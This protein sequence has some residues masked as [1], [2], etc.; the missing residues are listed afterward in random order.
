MCNHLTKVYLSH[1]EI[2]L[3][4]ILVPRWISIVSIKSGQKTPIQ[5]NLFR[6]KSG[7]LPCHDFFFHLL[8]LYTKPVN[9]PHSLKTFLDSGFWTSF[10]IRS[11]VASP[12]PVQSREQRS[13]QFPQKYFTMFVWMLRGIPGAFE[14]YFLSVRTIRPPVLVFWCKPIYRHWQIFVAVW[15]ETLRSSSGSLRRCG[16]LIYYCF[17]FYY[18]YCLQRHVCSIVLLFWKCHGFAW[19]YVCEHEDVVIAWPILKKLGKPMS[20]GNI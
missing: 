2:C 4:V 15:W 17:F 3:A 8:H 11:T 1:L 5:V 12:L 16:S 14:C 19:Y 20:G 13:E 6:R 7:L 18:I 9:S 10:Q